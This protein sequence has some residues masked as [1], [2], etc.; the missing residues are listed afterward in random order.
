MQKRAITIF[1]LT[2]ALCSGAYAQSTTPDVPADLQA[3]YR[4]LV[5]ATQKVD[6]DSYGKLLTEDFVLVMPDGS[7]LNRAVTL[8]TLNPD[9]MTYSKLDYRIEQAEITGDTARVT[10]W[11]EA[12]VTFKVVGTVQDAHV[13]NRSEDLWR[14][15]NG[16]WL[17]SESRTLETTTEASGQVTRQVAQAPLDE[18]TRAARRAALQA[19]LHPIS[20]AGMKVGLN[21]PAADFTWLGSLTATTRLLGLGE[22]S[23][24]TAEHFALKGR[25]FREL[26]EQHGFTVFMIEADFDDAYAIDRWVRGKGSESAEA[27]A[28][29]YDFW[30][31]QTQEMAD[32]LRWMRDYNAARGNKPELR[33]VGMDMQDPAGSLS[34]LQELTS[35]HSRLSYWATALRKEMAVQAEADTPDYTHAQALAALLALHARALKATDPHADEL[36]HLSRTVT[37]GLE[38]LNLMA[39]SDFNGLNQLRDRAMAENT[40]WLMNQM[41]SG[42]KAALWAH[43]FHVSKVPAEGQAYD[44]LGQHLAAALGQGY[45]VI[46]FSFGGGTLRAVP[47]KA[48]GWVGNEPVALTVPTALP[49]SLDGLSSSILGGMPN[50]VPAAF[51][52][53]AEAQAQAPLRDWLSQPVSISAVGALYTEGMPTSGPVNLPAAFDGLLLTPRS[54]AAVP[55]PAVQP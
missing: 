30:T 31:W 18:E 15:V 24:G 46:G 8:S 53:V 23:H 28:Q 26:V 34:L 35:P 20:A 12:D 38:M 21:A 47:S 17:L 49:D 43:N 1:A 6:A 22:G 41:F 7:R 2:T 51:L 54:T 48:D 16:Q 44:N 19:V 4:A 14:K 42:Q 52:S 3:A 50:P 9:Q 5:A 32:L 39:K 45:K 36:R 33:V 55:L 10:F 29:Q 13:E 25:L 40:L 37:Q 27:I 11:S